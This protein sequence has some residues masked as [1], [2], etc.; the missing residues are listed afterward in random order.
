METR[1]ICISTETLISEKNL[2]NRSH[3]GFCDDLHQEILIIRDIDFFIIGSD[4]GEEIFCED[5]VWAVV[6][7][8]ESEGHRGWKMKGKNS[9]KYS[10]EFLFLAMYDLIRELRFNRVHTSDEIIGVD[11]TICSEWAGLSWSTT[12]PTDEYHLFLG[13]DILHAHREEMEWDIASLRNMSLCIFPSST[14]IDEVYFFWSFFE[15]GSEFLGGDCEH[16]ED[17]KY[18]KN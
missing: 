16:N 9:L 11:T 7:G 4:R 13:I 14:D 15:D 8:V 1:D 18:R 12:R 17:I 3:S 2:R 6:L 10:E 5:A